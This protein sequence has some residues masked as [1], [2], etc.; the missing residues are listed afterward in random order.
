MACPVH[1]SRMILTRPWKVAKQR[2]G[3]ALWT[4]SPQLSNRRRRLKEKLP[5]GFGHPARVLPS[6]QHPVIHG[7]P[8]LGMPLNTW[9]LLPALH[10]SSLKMGPGSY[11]QYVVTPAKGETAQGSNILKQILER[12]S[13][14]L[15]SVEKHMALIGSSASG[16]RATLFIPEPPTHHS[17][18]VLLLHWTVPPGDEFFLSLIS[19]IL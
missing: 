12:S 7:I 4:F 13:D 19:L 9:P 17:G 11:R 2:T 16:I 3:L 15:Q 1:E 18:L 5:W 6:S 8:R 10:I 14:K